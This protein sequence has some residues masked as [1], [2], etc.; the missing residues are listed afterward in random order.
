METQT[1]FELIG[2]AASL[3]IAISLLMKSLIRLRIING[4]GALVFVVY[5]I[6][7]NAYPISL[8]NGI[9]VIIDSYYLIKMLQRSDYF[10]FMVVNPT[11]SYLQFFLNFHLEDIQNFFPEFVY[12][13]K[14]ED[15][16]FII[17]RDT[18]PAGLV[19]IRPDDHSGEI[20]LDYALKDYRDFKIGSFILDDN[21]QILWNQGIRELK[22]NTNIPS[23]AR[24]LERMGFL[25]DDGDRYT[26]ALNPAH[27]IDKKI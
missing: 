4:I 24:Y 9:I 5:G 23:H 7:I 11:S 22:T 25:N 17:L 13:P 21:P 18:I 19:I 12:I 1:I 10:S 15:F 14:P 6:L 3:L 8:L 26:K 16:I 27:I 20:I 2:Y